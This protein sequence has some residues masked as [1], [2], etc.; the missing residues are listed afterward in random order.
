MTKPT[1]VIVLAAS[2]GVMAHP[3]LAGLINN[4]SFVETPTTLTSTWD[5]TNIGGNWS[6]AAGVTGAFWEVDLVGFDVPALGV[7]DLVD[8]ATHLVNPPGH[9]D[10]APNFRTFFGYPAAS[11][12]IPLPGTPSWTDHP[13][14]C[15]V[16]QF[17][18]R[19]LGMK[20]HTNQE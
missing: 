5:W 14:I 16:P 18:G 15:G 20:E 6:A 2:W 9:I 13:G 4:T 8:I 10:I 7:G 3:A 1:F 19:L 11:A 12:G 17:G